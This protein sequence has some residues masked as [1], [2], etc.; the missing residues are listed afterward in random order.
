MICGLPSVVA[1]C[2]ADG[3]RRLGLGG[4]VERIHDTSDLSVE[5]LKKM[6]VVL[7]NTVK[8]ESVPL[9]FNFFPRSSARA[10]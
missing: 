1:A 3:Q 8:V 7:T 9:N 4:R 6:L 2:N 5:S 10:L